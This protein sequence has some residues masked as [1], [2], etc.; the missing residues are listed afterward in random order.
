MSPDSALE[1]S[2]S[3]ARSQPM[4]GKW[5]NCL[6]VFHP[7]PRAPDPFGTQLGMVAGRPVGAPTLPRGRALYTQ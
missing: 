3:C 7:L 1:K 2:L 6:A 5:A 4:A